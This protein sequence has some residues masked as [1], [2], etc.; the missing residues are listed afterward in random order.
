MWLFQGGSS[1]WG[2]AELSCLGDSPQ[3]PGQAQ[4]GFWEEFLPGKGWHSCP[5]QFPSLEGFQSP[6]GVTLGDMSG[7]FGSAGGWVVLGDLQGPFQSK[8]F[9]G[10][11]ESP[12]EQRHLAELVVLPQ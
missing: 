11:Q 10:F 5:G 8:A 3:L 2:G 1:G 12:G 7:G 9:R 4:G 6:V